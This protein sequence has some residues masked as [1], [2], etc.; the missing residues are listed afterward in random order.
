MDQ[1]DEMTETRQELEAALAA[2]RSVY[3]DDLHLH[4]QELAE[5]A[6]AE[7]LSLLVRALGSADPGWR[8]EAA[9][10][11]GFH[12]DLRQLPDALSALR[13]LL[14]EDPEATVRQAAAAVLPLHSTW[15]DAALY[16]ALRND[17]DA[18]VGLLAFE[19]LLKL[20]GLPPDD[21]KRAMRRA[22]SGKLAVSVEGLRQVV[23]EGAAELGGGERE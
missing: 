21:V 13:R 8:A 19:G 1:P 20:A 10:N 16:D 6:P 14:R 12:Y 7:A 17:R 18:L 23:G 15:P 11:L 2:G 22:R 9:Q 3:A 4:V 5:A